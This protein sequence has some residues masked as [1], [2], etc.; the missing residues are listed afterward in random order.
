MIEDTNWYLLYEPIF[1]IGVLI[2]LML[3]WIPTWV[4]R[5]AL[6]GGWRS[7][8]LAPSIPF[9]I[10]SRNTWPFMF[11]AASAA[12][13]IALLSLPAEVMNWEQ[14]R[15][16]VWDAFFIPWL[17]AI[18]SFVWWPLWLSPR[19]YRAWA[20]AGGTRETNPWTDEEVA[21]VHAKEPSKKQEKELADIA[22]CQAILYVGPAPG[23][24]AGPSTTTQEDHQS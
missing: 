17:F 15:Q 5:K 1:W 11:A 9:Q 12:L 7:W 13:A 8:T 10:S 4:A 3:W 16:T 24:A 18:L 21:A 2:A 6:G 14:V 22:R 19:W 23:E 20:K